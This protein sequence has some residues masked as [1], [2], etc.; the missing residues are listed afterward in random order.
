[1][2]SF[3]IYSEEVTLFQSTEY[4]KARVTQTGNAWTGI[5]RAHEGRSPKS[6]ANGNDAK[7]GAKWCVGFAEKIERQKGESR[8]AICRC[9]AHHFFARF[10]ALWG[11]ATGDGLGFQP[12]VGTPRNSRTPRLASGLP[13]DCLRANRLVRYI[14]L[15][16]LLLEV[17]RVHT[18]HR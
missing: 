4:E 1:M 9:G 18:I 8:R 14:I 7:T 17:F 12:E 5:L 2:L 6:G 10:S 11:A 13:H 15:A 16:H 3:C